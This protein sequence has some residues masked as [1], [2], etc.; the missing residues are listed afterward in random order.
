MTRV[1]VVGNLCRDTTLAVPRFP[2]PGET[3]VA[4]ANRTG[5]GGKGLNQAVAAARAGAEVLFH[6]AVGR[7]EAATLAADLA[8]EASLGMRLVEGHAATDTSTILLRPDGE[9][10]IVSACEAVLAFDPMASAA[11][12]DAI[13]SG[14]LFLMQGNLSRAATLGC[15]REARR[16][17]AATVL[18]P[19]PLWDDGGPAWPDVNVLVANAGELRK[20]SG[21]DDA[22]A[23]ATAL[24]AAGATAVVVT[25]GAEGVLYRDADTRLTVAAS[26]VAVV[27][28]TGAGDVFCGVFVGLL[29]QGLDRGAALARA[30]AAASLSVTRQGALAS[31]PSAV[32]IAALCPSL[33]FR[34]RV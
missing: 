2:A 28:T 7:G 19:S 3:M 24:L 32:E 13:V 31:I 5:P 18:N 29:A 22:D 23:A 16:R 10:L 1:H 11:L 26:P 4:S 12:M 27:D 17:G 21:V 20:L 33:T 9:N 30:T 6:A 25:R 34:S 14:D 8:G 15:L